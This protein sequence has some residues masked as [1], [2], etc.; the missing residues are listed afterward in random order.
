MQET[1]TPTPT[2][3]T[4]GSYE[5]YAEAQSAVDRLA[6]RKFP[7][8]QV[9]ILGSDLQIVE[10]VTGARNWL[11]VLLGGFGSGALLGALL[12]FVLGLFS[13]VD[14]LVSGIALALWGALL[15]GVIGAFIAGVAYALSRGRRDFDSVSGITATRF[16]VVAEPDAAEEARR[17][18]A[19]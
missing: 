4:I 19:Q 2:R 6:D 9:S 10:Q 15:A 18:L 12:G 14:P 16:D 3:S 1:A 13:L 8:Q 11:S 5:T 7:V 17:I